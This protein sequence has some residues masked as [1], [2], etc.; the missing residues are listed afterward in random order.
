MSTEQPG[1]SHKDIPI[2]VTIDE[3]DGRTRAKVR[4]LW[5]GT[6]YVGVGLARCNPAD[7]DVAEIGDELALAR[8][9]SDL[10]RQLLSVTADDIRAATDEPVSPLR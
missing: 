5:R 8:G 10:A 9:L 6:E 2:G 1:H 3:D 4:L 7:R